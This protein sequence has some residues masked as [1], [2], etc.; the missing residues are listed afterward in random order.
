MKVSSRL[1]FSSSIGNVT[2]GI[3]LHRINGHLKGVLKYS[4]FLPFA[5]N[6]ERVIFCKGL[7]VFFQYG[8]N[9]LE[10]KTVAVSLNPTVLY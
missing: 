4:D 10:I 1:T 7:V 2:A 8:A 3:D 5:V 9:F 6:P